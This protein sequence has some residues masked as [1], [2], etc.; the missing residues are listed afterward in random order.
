MRPNQNPIERASNCTL[1]ITFHKW[2]FNSS[3]VLILCQYSFEAVN[4]VGIRSFD[5]KLQKSL[6][7]GALIHVSNKKVRSVRRQ[8]LIAMNI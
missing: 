7:F 3:D 5:K 2:R 1:E 6:F 4:F 8:H